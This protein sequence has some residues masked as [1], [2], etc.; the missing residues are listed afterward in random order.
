MGM[1]ENISIPVNVGVVLDLDSDLDGKIALSCIEMAL[2][3]FY[4]THG[5]Y[6]TRLVLNTRDSMKDVVGAAAAG[7]LSLSLSPFKT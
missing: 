7:S 5:D 2:S 4:A 6:R 1:A 3:D